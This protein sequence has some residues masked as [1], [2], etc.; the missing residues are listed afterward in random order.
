LAYCKE[1]EKKKPV[2]FCG[3]F[4]VAHTQ[5]DLAHPQANEGQH[6]FTLEEREGFHNFVASGFVDTFRLFHQ[7]KGF[8]TWWSYFANARAHNVG[9][10]LDYFLVSESLCPLVKE[11][12]ILPEVMGSDHCPVGIVLE[13]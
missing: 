10:R 9:W 3:D 6:G 13:I 1:L 2:I 4:N 8:Y 7:G 12:F 5:D 11:A